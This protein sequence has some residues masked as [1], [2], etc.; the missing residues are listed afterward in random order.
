MPTR[1]PARTLDSQA[2]K[3]GVLGVRARRRAGRGA[4]AASGGGHAVCA[5]AGACRLRFLG[6]HRS[7]TK[8]G[9]GRGALPSGD[10]RQMTQAS[11]NDHSVRGLGRLG[12]MTRVRRMFLFDLRGGRPSPGR[13]PPHTSPPKAGAQRAPPSLPAPREDLKAAACPVPRRRAAARPPICVRCVPRAA[14]P[15]PAPCAGLR[16]GATVA[17]RLRGRKRPPQPKGR[18]GLGCGS[19]GAL[20]PTGGAAPGPRHTPRRHQ[21]GAAARGALWQPAGQ[22]LWQGASYRLNPNT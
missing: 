1:G 10:R 19:R 21:Q 9:T 14:C 8:W 11:H 13:P 20:L 16:T 2:L 7:F 22:R 4:C 3:G 5:A 18:P 17:G 15:A 12:A 6:R